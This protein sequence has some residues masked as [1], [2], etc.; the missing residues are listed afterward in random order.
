MGILP[1]SSF[2]LDEETE[3]GNGRCLL[4]DEQPGIPKA[5][6]TM[7]WGVG[8]LASS[9]FPPTSSSSLEG[10]RGPGVSAPPVS[11]CPPGG[12]PGTESSPG[13]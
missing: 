9:S 13:S 10:L 1:G 2:F 5:G 11:P 12:D 8:S 3:A 4:E 6:K 7:G